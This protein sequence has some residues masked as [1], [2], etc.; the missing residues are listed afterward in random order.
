MYVLSY[1]CAGPLSGACERSGQGST[2]VFSS[3]LFTSFS[4]MGSLPE[5]R[6]HCLFRLTGQ[7][8]LREAGVP[9]ALEL[10]GTCH[11]AQLHILVLRVTAQV[12]APA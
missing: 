7:Q 6:F 12:L 10:T 3:V 11:H 8:A 2:L 1:V 5:L 4:E 9:L